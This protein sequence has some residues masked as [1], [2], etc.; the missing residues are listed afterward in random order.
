MDNVPGGKG[1]PP[2][3]PGFAGR[4]PA[5]AP[6]F[7]QKR[8]SGGG[9]NGAVDPAAAQQCFVGGIDDGGDFEPGDVAFD[10]GHPSEDLGFGHGVF[11]LPHFINFRLRLHLC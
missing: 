10:D 7:L 9:M 3:D 2:G 1:V 8:R 6:A 11:P 5:E 4:A